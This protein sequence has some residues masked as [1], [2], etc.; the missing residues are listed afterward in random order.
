MTQH[1]LSKPDCLAK[2]KAGLGMQ[3]AK[4]PPPNY[5]KPTWKARTEP[6]G[7]ASLP[8]RPPEPHDSSPPSKVPRVARMPSP[9]S[10][11][12]EQGYTEKE[13]TIIQMQ[14]NKHPDRTL[15]DW[16]QLAAKS[17]TA[18]GKSVDLGH[19]SLTEEGTMGNSDV[20]FG[21]P[22]DNDDDGPRLEQD[23]DHQGHNIGYQAGENNNNNEGNGYRL[24]EDVEEGEE[25]FNNDGYLNCDV[26]TKMRDRFQ[27]FCMEAKSN[28]YSELEDAQARGVRLL[29]ILHKKSRALDAYG[30]VHLWYFQEQGILDEDQTLKDAKDDYVSREK[31]LNDLTKRYNMGSKLPIVKPTILPFSREKVE[32]VCRDAWGCIEQLLTDPR[33]TDDDFWFPDGD[34]FADPPESPSVIGDLQTGRAF[35]VAHKE[36]KKT[37]TTSGWS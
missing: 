4:K 19:K 8:L 5:D 25:D 27:A 1:I 37:A 26:D 2:E 18:G 24:N 11:P 22:D 12:R 7:A 34:P 20:D 3:T 15:D 29:N 33:L 35:R 28:W 16:A 9:E 10:A 32:L 21:L 14:L 23:S 13:L 6:F 31:L 30:D 17:L 36:Y